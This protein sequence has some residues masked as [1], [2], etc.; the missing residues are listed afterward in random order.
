MGKEGPTQ[1][2]QGAQ[3]FGENNQNLEKMDAEMVETLRQ[4]VLDYRM[5]GIVG[6]RHEI[7]RIKKNR[8]F[9]QGLH[10]N[11]GWD[12]DTQE[13][14][15]P[16]G[17]SQ[18]LQW[19]DDVEEE[20][21]PRYEYVTN[22]YQG[23]GLSFIAVLSQDVPTVHW[24]PQ[25]ANNEDDIAT[26]KA[27]SEIE[28]L[29][30]ENNRVEQ[31][32]IKIGEDLW[33]DGKLGGYV[34]YVADGQR[35]GFHQNPIVE[36]QFQKMGQDAFACPQCQAETPAGQM[37]AGSVCPQCGTQLSQ[38]NFQPAPQIPVPVVTGYQK[39]PNGQ[40]VISIVGGLELNTP[41]WANERHEMPYTQWQLEVHEA[42]LRAAYPWAADKIQPGNPNDADDVYSRA[43]RIAV[44]QGLPTTHPGDALYSLI[45]FT[46]NWIRPW[47]FMS[48]KVKKDVRARLLKLFPDGCYVAFAGD[49]YCESRNEGMDDHWRFLHALPGD[50]QNRPAVGD[51]VV[52]AQERYNQ[53]SNIHMEC[54]EYG[55]PT[56]FADAQVLDFE[57]LKGKDAQP[58]SFNPVRQ[59]PGQPLQNSFFQSQ[60]ASL[61]ADWVA[62]A[63]E[64]AGPTMQFL[65]GVFPAIFGGDMP[66]Q[67]TA[68]GYGMARD[69]AMG[70]LGLF[71]RALK[72]WWAEVMQLAVECFRKNRQS[73]VQQAVL[74]DDGQ[75]QAKV[76]S[77]ADLRGNI[78]ARAEADETFPR[79]KSQQ[80]AIVQQLL[81]FAAEAPEVA[82]MMNEPANMRNIHNVMGLDDFSIPGED[83]ANKQLREIQD[84]LKAQPIQNM[85]PGP[86]GPQPQ[87]SS[88]VPVDQLLDR[89]ADEFAE[90]QRWANSSAGIQAKRQNPAGFANVRAHAAEHQKSMQQGDGGKKP[91]SES[92]NFKD[93]PPDGKAQMAGQAGIQ[94]NPAELAVKEATDKAQKSEEL[95][96][97]FAAKGKA[98]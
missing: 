85:V 90:C 86:I 34:R 43:S 32:L 21:G 97:R 74:G 12:A 95:Q 72:T 20:A 27:A 13:W 48:N 37:Y 23:Y 55:I 84:L 44:Q 10:Y 82:A 68:A 65:S 3:D 81:G 91:P 98:A 22:W 45:T 79:L 33:L 77:I 29:V 61:P 49:T 28:K 66:D 57:S 80:R 76:I 7:R 16:S 1:A 19:N 4:L 71:W 69:Q 35:F 36:A 38:Q 41:V 92:I 87:I 2:D 26:A 73:D 50:G 25:D 8:L 67:K 63:Q 88:T 47:A 39:V 58:G 51:A 5:E 94:L 46:R 56:T 62:Y 52:S 6:R 54:M 11:T 15:M 31:L 75:Y 24:Y 89:H 9:W 83:S 78:Q 64:L 40:E 17:T 53:Y 60:A 30:Q 70:R 59:K 42:K 93:L 14:Q 96:A 18:G